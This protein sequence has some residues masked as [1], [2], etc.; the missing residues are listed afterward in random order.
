[1][2]KILL[3][4]IL[5]VSIG[6]SGCEK[7][8]EEANTNTYNPEKANTAGLLRRAQ[9]EFS[10]YTQDSWL[11]GRMGM[12]Y[13]QFWSQVSYTNESRYR[14]RVGV[15]DSRWE[16]LYK[17][18]GSFKEIIKVIENAKDN[19]N[20]LTRL[21]TFGDLDNQI[22]VSRI[23]KAYVLH[24]ITDIWGDI[25]YSEALDLDKSTHPK[26]DLQKDIYAD[27]LKELTEAQE[28]IDVDKKGVV[29]DAV[30]DGDMANWK[31]FA[32]SL[33]MRIACRTSKVDADYKVKVKA[34]FDAGAFTSND[35]NAAFQYSA[36]NPY[37]N[38]LN[39]DAKTRKDFAISESFMETLKATSDPRL[40]FYADPTVSSVTA[41]APEYVGTVYGKESSSTEPDEISAP[42]E[43]GFGVYKADYAFPL[44]N[45]DEVCF[46]M[47]EIDGSEAQMRKG[48][49]ASCEFW[50]VKEGASEVYANT[51]DFSLK[52]N[53]VQKYTAL[54]VQGIQAWSEFRRTG[55]P[56][57]LRQ[58]AFGILDNAVPVGTFP[59][60]RYYPSTSQN[61]NK[62]N[63]DVAVKRQGED[64][65]STKVWWDK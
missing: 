57:N 35:Q 31:K 9:F 48:I 2:K 52:M 32:N 56:D 58:P 12:M 34:A 39:E 5:A 11:N 21:K 16:R 3:L 8:F 47:A 19:P 6:F 50:G 20:E 7:N 29:G 49:A 43:V 17:A 51:V 54:Y 18:A 44:M 27:L 46:I 22:A 26:F 25:P 62:A 23:M 30:Y 42:A 15:T 40:E 1:M 53:A 41:G 33:R 63:Y 38:P 64:K 24:I 36:L 61:L 55:F 10:Y 28:M 4:L 59:R 65:L 13:S 37:N 14:P 45:Y 60:R